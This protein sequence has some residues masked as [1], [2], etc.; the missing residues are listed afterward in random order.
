VVRDHIGGKLLAQVGAQGRAIDRG[1]ALQHQEGD[2]PV[3]AVVLAQHHG[4]LANSRQKCD[5]GLD[6]AELDAEPADLDLV[7][8][9]P[10]ESDVAG[11]IEADGVAG[12]VQDG[13][14]AVAAERVRDELLVRE[15]GALEVAAGDPRAADEKLTLH[16]RTEEVQL[17]VDD[18]AGVIRDRPADRHRL[19][20]VH[21]GDRCDDR[22]FRRPVGVEHPP[23][24]RRPAGDERRRQ[25]LAA[26]QDQ[27]Q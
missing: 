27:T 23:S 3:D 24:R 26:Q 11:R 19:S 1:A 14:A 17:V 10:V 4:G 21:L 15:L 8:D 18:V 13:V 22:R 16:P 20:G 2:E 12:A 7:V 6:L 9:A 5:L 25:R